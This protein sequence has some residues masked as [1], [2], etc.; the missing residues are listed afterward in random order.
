LTGA[1]WRSWSEPFAAPD[2]KLLLERAALC[3][4]CPEGDA[5][6][7]YASTAATRGL[8]RLLEAAAE[9]LHGG[10]SGVILVRGG[11]GW[12][13]THALA[14]L[15]LAASHGGRAASAAPEALRGAVEALA[16]APTAVSVFDGSSTGYRDVVRD[17]GLSSAWGLVA[18]RLAEAA[19]GGLGFDLRGPPPGVGALSS[20]LSSLERRGLRPVILVD[21]AD[22]YVEGVEGAARGASEGEASRL[23][24]EAQHFL[25]FLSALAEAVSASR[26]SLLVVSVTAGSPAAGRVAEALGDALAVPDPVAPDELGEVL[27]ARLVEAV[28]PG[29]AAGVAEE[30]SRLYGSMGLSFE[31]LPGSYPFHP[32]LLEAL[33]R[34]VAGSPSHRGAAS[35]LS[36]AWRA[37]ARSLERGGGRDYVLPGDLDVLDRG[38]LDA[39]LP[40]G[41][42]GFEGLRAAAE[43]DAEAVARV[44][45]ML[46]AEGLR[47]VASGL[48]AHILLWSASGKPLPRPA[49]AAGV[50]SPMRRVGFDAAMRALD[51]LEGEAVHLHVS[52]AG[53]VKHY[54][55]K[56]KANL[57]SLA[58]REA[59]RLLSGGERG[60]VAERVK[61]LLVRLVGRVDPPVEVVVWPREPP[62]G[63][64]PVKLVLLGSEGPRAPEVF[65]AAEPLV[66]TLAVLEPDAGRLGEALEA[67]AASMGL[68]GLVEAGALAGEDAEEAER[69]ARLL[70]ARA[71]EALAAAYSRLLYPAPG[72]LG[73]ARL[74]VERILTAGLWAAVREALAR[75]GKLAFD[76]LEPALLEEIL[77]S[78][79]EASL[80]ELVDEV[81]RNPR[82]PLVLRPVEAVEAAARRLV[83]SGRAA[84][85]GGEEPCARDPGPL[86][87]SARLLSCREAVARGLCRPRGDGGCEPVRGSA[88]EA[89][90]E[91]GVS[92]GAAE[93]EAATQAA[94]LR[95]R[96]VSGRVKPRELAAFLRAAAGGAR[97]EGLRVHLEG[98][99]ALGV[100]A[101]RAVLEAI[102]SLGWGRRAARV[103]VEVV[104]GSARVSVEASGEPG[105]VAA[106]LRGVWALG[107]PASVEVDASVEGLGVDGARL[108]EAL[109]SSPLRLYAG[110]PLRVEARISPS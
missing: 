34:L 25:S 69:L 109:A 30:Y 37:A 31:G 60:R 94:A 67:A 57:D 103:G 63:G 98:S 33:R 86:E 26:S 12:G 35:A 5:R 41:S 29:G 2:F 82:L 17:Y 36:A 75:A 87:P 96:V 11:R 76:R 110:P 27:R 42:G 81:A 101:A 47:G 38:D 1:V 40:R 22:R 85:A 91:G 64:W 88:A 108:A 104:S 71:R 58:R 15:A 6:L 18:L 83:A 53:G 93:V 7:F 97:V 24:R 49:A 92:R 95:G 80:E 43:R 84:V 72:G 13:K 4:E 79:G 56:S 45:E 46:A 9:R 89:P 61:S 106:A 105:G 44:E 19:G 70:E 28:D 23:R 90:A 73:E 3:G 62:G 78:R 74:G 8:T 100:A 55:I 99:G 54:I 107:E 68:R 39:V 65:R 16:R 66:N 10:G 59:R 51:L 50:A 102:E 21:D 48:Y 77:A 52:Q 20:L 14:A 32:L